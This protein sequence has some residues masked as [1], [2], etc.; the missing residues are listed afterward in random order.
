M[1]TLQEIFAET[2][3]ILN[4]KRV[5]Q[6]EMNKLTVMYFAEQKE[7]EVNAETERKIAKMG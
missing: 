6:Q 2:N 4:E 7:L 5:H 3:S 1:S